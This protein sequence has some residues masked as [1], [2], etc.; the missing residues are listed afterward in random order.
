MDE[1][2]QVPSTDDDEAGPSSDEPETHG[3]ALPAGVVITSAV[4]LP[5]APVTM[6]A[7]E[8][9]DNMGDREKRCFESFISSQLDSSLVR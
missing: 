5:P 6:G 2:E 8:N 3:E 1:V 7:A 9:Y 4:G